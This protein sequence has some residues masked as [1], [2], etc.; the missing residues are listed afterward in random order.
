MIEFIINPSAQSGRGMKI[1]KKIEEMM[2]DT[3][4]YKKYFTRPNRSAAYIAETIAADGKEHTFVVL[5]GDGTINAVI[6]GIPLDGR[7]TIGY[8]P[9]GSGNDFARALGIQGEPLDMLM[10]MLESEKRRSIS[11][12]EMVVQ[13]KFKK[14]FIVSTGIGLD[15][16][17]CGMTVST[18]FKKI[19][20]ALHIGNLVYGM[21]ALE[22][23]IKYNSASGEVIIDG[24]THEFS[25]I[26]FSSI[27]NCPYEGGGFQFC[28]KADFSDDV[29][30][31][32][33]VNANRKWK[34]IPAF[35]TLLFGKHEE[36]PTV[37]MLKGK[38]VTI[39]LDAYRDC[40]T[41]GEVLCE[42]HELQA[43]ICGSVDFIV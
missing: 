24:E 22:G 6:N 15:A 34:I 14:R 5:G 23:I 16:Q 36:M 3:V 32:C 41:D 33:V 12:G 26:L 1:W 9:T 27:Q 38:N 43:S 19:L 20:N 4:E 18:L 2:P 7:I 28:P 30:D 37:T 17:I 10:N 25:N 13:G 35:V 40:H 31:V 29:L 21:H 11:V 42:S 39:S 8:I